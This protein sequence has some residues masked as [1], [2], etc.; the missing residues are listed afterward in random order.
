MIDKEL[1]SEKIRNITVDALRQP[2]ATNLNNVLEYAFTKMAILLIDEFEKE[3]KDAS[4]KRV[5][6]K[7]QRN[8]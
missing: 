1:V 3:Y 7:S 5:N 8:A 2:T 6:Q 4:L